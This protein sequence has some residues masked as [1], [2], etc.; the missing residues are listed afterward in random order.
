M[1]I[2]G[3]NKYECSKCKFCTKEKYRYI[4]HLKTNKH[5]SVKESKTYKC[6]RCNFISDDKYN[7]NKH[8]HSRKHTTEIINYKNICECGKKY[9]YK[10]SLITH[11]LNCKMCTDTGQQ[12]ETTINLIVSHLI[13]QKE[14]VN[15]LYSKLE[16]QSSKLE[17]Q[18][19]KLEEQSSKLEELKKMKPSQ[20]TNNTTNILL[21]LN[22]RF[23]DAMSLNDF[24][25][26]MLIKCDHLL[27]TGVNGVD[28]GIVNILMDNMKD[29]HICKRPI[30]SN[31]DNL[32]I[33]GDE[34]WLKDQDQTEIKKATK[35]IQYKQIK[36]IN[37]YEK[38]NPNWNN[39]ENT[40][41]E[42]TTMLSKVMS[43]VDNNRVIREIKK[44]KN[45]LDL[46]NNE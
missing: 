5:N 29:L 46:I 20:I 40:Q 23:S 11:K 26:N 7:Y 44:N 39:A 42:Y 8:L 27:Y 37:L 31:K 19:S 22:E 43:D 6:E 41:L 13:E 17:E 45:E 15:K 36:N 3:E 14:L 33:K 9:K 10:Q 32:F 2:K 25:N 12:K 21:V 1:E 34:A 4:R 18:S 16:E 35:K 28:K 30:C 24:I 38:E